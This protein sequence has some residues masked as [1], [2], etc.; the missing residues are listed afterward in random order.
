MN[1]H[2]S[3]LPHVLGEAQVAGLRPKFTLQGDPIR[4]FML[5]LFRKK[6]DFFLEI[7]LKKV[8]FLENDYYFQCLAES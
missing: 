2:K 3:S 7:V 4:T 1:A 6:Y 8:I 5:R